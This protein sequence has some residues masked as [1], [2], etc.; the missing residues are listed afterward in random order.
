ML[1]IKV[2][3]VGS[4]GYYLDLASED[5]YFNGG[6]P[7][8]KWVGSGCRYFNLAGH[9][10]RE[11]FK[12]IFNGFHPNANIGPPAAAKEDLKPKPLVQN[13]GKENRRAGWDLT[14]SVPKSISVIWSQA[15]PEMQARIQELHHQAVADTLAFVEQN[16]AYARTGKAGMGQIVPV[17]L[18]AAVFEHGTSRASDPQLHSHAVVMN[19]TVDPNNSEQTRSLET[20][21]IFKNKMLLGAIYRSHLAHSLHQ[22][23][24]FNAERK[25]NSF[26]VQG[27]PGEVMDH[28]STRRKQILAHLKKQGRSGAVAAAEA[29]ILTRGKKEHVARGELINAWRG[30]N[31]QLGFDDR[32][33]KALIC[34]VATN[35]DRLIPKVLQEAF[36]N[37]KHRLNHFTAHD[38]L[39][40]VLYVAPN[41]GVS[42]DALYEPVHEFLRDSTDIVPIA[43]TDGSRRF[44]TTGVLEQELKLLK[45]LKNLH[46]RQGCRVERETLDKVLKEHPKL[47]D[48][49]QKAVRHVTR[50]DKAIRIVQGYAGTGKTTMLRTAVQA[51]Q[52]AGFNVVGACFTGAA[53]DT[54]QEEI[55]VPCDTINMTLADFQGD[56]LDTLRR[57]GKHSFRQLGRA[58]LKKKTH[59]F[60]K[61]QPADINRKTIVLLDE[62]GMINTRHMLMLL[63]WVEKNQATIV[64]TGDAAQLPAV[65]GGSPFLSLSKRVGYTEMTDIKRQED[66]WARSAAYHMARGE[67]CKALALY[68]QRNLVK[69]S[70]EMEAALQQLIKDWADH[71]YDRPADARILTL[72]NDQAHSANQLAQEQ[73]IQRNMLDVKQRHTIQDVDE[74]TGRCYESSVHVGD[75]VLFTEN[76]RTYGVRN[77]NTG[78]VLAFTHVGKTF[79][80]ALRVKL[81][82][83]RTVHVPVSYR[84]IRLGYASTVHKAQ[85]G[86]FPEVFVLLGGA[87]QNLPISYVQ[88]TRSR[89]ATHFYTERALYD[90]IQ[91][92]EESPLVSQM[93]R[94][95]DLSLAADLFVPPSGMADNREDLL[96]LLL[97]DWQ[98]HTAKAKRPS[99][100]VTKD[101][102]DAKR[103]NAECHKR[104]YAM[105]QSNWEENQRKHRSSSS[106]TQSAMPTCEHNGTSFIVGD[107]LRFLRESFADSILMHELGTVTG[108]FPEVQAIEVMLDR[109]KPVRVAMDKLPQCELAYAASLERAQQLL[110]HPKDVFA[111][112]PDKFQRSE[113]QPDYS[114][115]TDYFQWQPTPSQPTT[116]YSPTLGC[117]APS[118]QPI[119]P[120]ENVWTYTSPQQSQQAAAWHQQMCQTNQITSWNIQQQ[121]TLQFGGATSHEHSFEQRRH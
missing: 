103:L 98:R 64:L 71:A 95:V 65:E 28:H 15:T 25:G 41:Y 20:K 85:G 13:A 109:G 12:R 24:G 59:R 37:L 89:L 14:F 46:D 52:A 56:L 100:I 8:G 19:V 18:V 120:P 31:E 77:G 11:S 70:D 81:D 22:E 35:Y 86:T 72:T 74:E 36:Q 108:I 38:F 23:F 93:E 83:G 62:A 87:A 3:K 55:G 75:R 10:E 76:N 39:R 33:L 112:E 80:P 16:L 102:H 104:R 43:M 67:I 30:E 68:D 45:T 82:N 53:A 117:S 116:V 114:T 49:Q 79:R 121:Q 118:W 61:P 110:H 26:E 29:A 27:V 63:D 42:P 69:V 6:E 91:D 60:K 101:D 78:T 106:T 4:E 88:G 7:P 54:L 9:V 17:K 50:S 92:L 113:M 97:T 57:W 111:L 66:Y 73:L 84:H 2:I 44:T 99:L 51:W 58:A 40:E 119:A 105:A 48:E 5:Y 32:A 34:P 90:Q 47:N 96:N 1:S 94:E 21:P 107:R 115:A